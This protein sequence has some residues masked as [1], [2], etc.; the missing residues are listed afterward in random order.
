MPQDSFPDSEIDL[1]NKMTVKEFGEVLPGMKVGEEKELTVK[2]D[3][4]Y[5][6]P[7]FAGAEIRY[8]CK[9]REVKE[10]VLPEINDAFAK[11]TGMALYCYCFD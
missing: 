5:P 2:Y 6:D 11:S 1:G 7:T 10:R 8:H 9:V 4:D 3:A